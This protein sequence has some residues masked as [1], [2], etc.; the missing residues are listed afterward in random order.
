MN[1]VTYTNQGTEVL[2]CVVTSDGT[3][4]VTLTDSVSEVKCVVWTTISA[5]V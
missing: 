2:K 3:L 4:L 5:A 1:I